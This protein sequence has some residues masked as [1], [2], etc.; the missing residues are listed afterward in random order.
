MLQ[1]LLT[2]MTSEIL[3]KYEDKV[4]NNI[5]VKR[6]GVP[7]DISSLTKLASDKAII[8]QDKL[9]MLMEECHVI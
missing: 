9:F 1:A 3:E 5:P 2:A 8:L 6:I 7:D 4:I